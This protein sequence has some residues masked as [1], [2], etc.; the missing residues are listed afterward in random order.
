MTKQMNK[1]KK[2]RNKIQTSHVSFSIRK[3]LLFSFLIPV[4]FIAML[5]CISYSQ[6]SKGL[7]ESYESST[8]QSFNAVANHLK[9]GFSTV[10]SATINFAFDTN[11]KRYATG[12]YT[13]NSYDYMNN[14]NI[15]KN[16][17]QT[18]QASNEFIQNIMLI[19]SDDKF[20]VSSSL[21]TSSTKGFYKEL[22]EANSYGALPTGFWTSS[23]D[24]IDEKLRITYDYVLSFI[25]PVSTCNCCIV[26]DI[27]TDTITESLSKLC[28]EDSIIGFVTSDGQELVLDSKGALVED[29]AENTFTSLNAYTDSVASENENG[30]S[31]ITYKNSK[32][33]FMYQKIKDTG[34]TIVGLIPKSAM[35]SAAN[36][37]KQ[38]TIIIV[39]LSL[40]VIAFV[41]IVLS[42]NI[43]SNI[44][45]LMKQF[46]KVSIGDLTVE[47][48]I[49]SRDELSMLAESIRQTLYKI[50]VLIQNVSDTSKLVASSANSVISSSDIMS[51]LTENVS[52]S[53]HQITGTI[54]TEANEAQSCVNEME[55][56]SNK[57]NL[58]NNK[59]IDI[60]S[61]ANQTKDM[62]LNNITIMQNINQ[63][64]ANT[65]HIMNELSSKMSSL[66]S[67]SQ[68]VNNFIEVINGISE[69]TNLLSLN[70]S[71]EAARAGDSGKGFSVVAEEIRKLSEE[72]AAAAN[73]IKK[74]ADDIT[75]QTKETVTQVTNAENIVQIQNKT[76]SEMIEAFHSLEQGI[77]SLFDNLTEIAS[78][79]K[80]VSAARA[81]TLDSISNISA[82]TEETYS[83][84]LSVDNILSDQNENVQQ[85]KQLSAELQQKAKELE[86]SIGIFKI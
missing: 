38:T 51:S 18:N 5:G 82:S 46:E 33:C 27:K 66:E 36:S 42:N 2:G 67:K 69:Q 83:V 4:F 78:Q 19:P 85:L 39:L 41:I 9:F 55:T 49:H 54:E 86:S 11:V 53:I 76:I 61:F 59:V 22:K 44:R 40:L 79:T 45:K 30:Y 64:S 81:T 37:I 12:Y 25:R 52:Q 65:S 68:S 56:L 7:I 14:L 15:V 75:L 21:N 47:P 48:V 58:I 50:R 10:S 31:Y 60:E 43:G 34:C 84:S 29:A 80:D 26:V 28:T 8:L 62:V 71:I 1:A 20:V 24:M 35:I 63:Y 73:K 13:T 17:F 77:H 72:S 23:H 6:S 57:I 32:Y 70:A 74:V 3:K 16:N